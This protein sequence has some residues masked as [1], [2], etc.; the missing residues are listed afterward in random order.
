MTLV[1]CGTTVAHKG[2]EPL[3]SHR[4]WDEINHYSNAPEIW[5]TAL[6]VVHKGIEPLPSVWKTDMRRPSTPMDHIFIY[7]NN[8]SMKTTWCQVIRH[9]ASTDRESNPDCSHTTGT[10]SHYTISADKMETNVFKTLLHHWPDDNWTHCFHECGWRDS[11]PRF[12]HGEAAILTRLIHI[13]ILESWCHMSALAWNTIHDYVGQ[14]GFEPAYSL[15]FRS[16]N[17]ARQTKFASAHMDEHEHSMIT[18]RSYHQD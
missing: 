16:H 10:Q 8:D 14:T 17:P 13:R 4:E 6:K 15:L 9:V 1:A 18:M 5:N 7:I 12:R 11:N 2:I 3:P